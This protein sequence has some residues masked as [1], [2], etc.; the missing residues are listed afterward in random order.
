MGRRWQ[1]LP[2]VARTLA[3]AVTDAVA[4]ARAEDEP[5]LRAAADRLAGLDPTQPGRVLGDTVRLLLEQTHPDG[6]D[7]DDLRTVL[8]RCARW[9][10]GWWPE[11][12]PHVLA[13]L[14]TRALGVQ[15]DPEAMPALTAQQ[16]ATHAPLLLADLLANS[17][18]S[19]TDLLDAVFTELRR[20]GEM[21]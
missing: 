4:A 6:L 19:L 16:S 5:A 13:A 3:E 12:D 15:P 1:D 7:A 14:L 9:A 20:S 10:A 2:P 18:L 8:G 11:T 21:D 17:W